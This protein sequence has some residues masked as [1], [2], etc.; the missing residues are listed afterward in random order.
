MT[1]PFPL[2]IVPFRH[3]TETTAQQEDEFYKTHAEPV[4]RWLRA[5]FSAAG[6]VFAALR[7]R[8]SGKQADTPS[9]RPVHSCER[10]CSGRDAAVQGAYSPATMA[11]PEE[12]F[13]CQTSRSNPVT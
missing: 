6:R 5:P 2:P 3:K 11:R 13:P 7:K 12:I 4:P 10:D 8:W 9:A 1:Y